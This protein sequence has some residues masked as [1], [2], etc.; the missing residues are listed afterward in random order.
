MPNA[1][2]VE[3]DVPRDVV[4]NLEKRGHKVLP[5]PTLGTVQAV[6]IAPE[7]LTAASDPRYGGAPAAP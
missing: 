7:R 2:V 5:T 3:P 1:L 6:G 4:V